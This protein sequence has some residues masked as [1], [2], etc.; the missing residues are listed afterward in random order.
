MCQVA[1]VDFECMSSHYYYYTRIQA[2]ENELR[3]TRPKREERARES[4]GQPTGL[5]TESSSTSLKD[6]QVLSPAVQ[7]ETE[8]ERERERKEREI[9]RSRE[10]RS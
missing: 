10:E 2:A 8:R 1:K 3:T 7:I 9:H 6:K 4:K 5:E